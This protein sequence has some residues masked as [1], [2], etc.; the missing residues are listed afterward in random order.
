MAAPGVAACIRKSA[1]L[2]SV[3]APS[4]VRAA[5]LPGPDAVAGAPRPRPPL[6]GCGT[7]T[8][9]PPWVWTPSS[10]ASS[11]LAIVPLALELLCWEP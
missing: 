6:P 1:Q 8:M 10:V 11:G 4:A 9:Q 3:S 7:T 5:L 2:L